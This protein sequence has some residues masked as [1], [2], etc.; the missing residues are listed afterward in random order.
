ML[1][2]IVVRFLSSPS[3]RAKRCAVAGLVAGG[4]TQSGTTTVSCDPEKIELSS[5]EWRKKLRPSAYNILRSRATE[6]PGS[7]EFI[8]FFPKKGYFACGGCE[9]PLYSTGAKFMDPGWPAWDQCFYSPKQ[10]CHVAVRSGRM[11]CDI[12][13]SRCNGYLGHV[14]FGERHT[15]ANERH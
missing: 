4:V 15:R 10:G 14:F 5:A 8:R 6:S 7:S 13:C 2:S 11:G 3:P 9:L 1:R 12:S